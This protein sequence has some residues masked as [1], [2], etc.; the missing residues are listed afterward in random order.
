LKS[1]RSRRHRAL[2]S[3]LLEARKSAKIARIESGERR[4]D[5]VEFIDMAKALHVDPHKLI[6]ELIN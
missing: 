3:L 5:V 6:A 1:L 2:C 4:V